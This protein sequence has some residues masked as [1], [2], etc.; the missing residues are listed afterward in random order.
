MNYRVLA[1]GAALVLAAC[2]GQ[3]A[4]NEAANEAAGEA[5]NSAEGA[6]AAEAAPA[7]GTAAATPAKGAAPTKDFM[8]GKWGEDGEC[9][10]ALD[11]KADGSLVGPVDR[12]ELNGAELTL[13]GLPQK[14][15]LSVIDDKTMESRLDGTGEPRRLTRC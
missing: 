1:A 15:V 7:A 11:F 3:P 2:G 9:E 13:V 6:P 10:L 8:V 4:A 12:W 14:M 5:S